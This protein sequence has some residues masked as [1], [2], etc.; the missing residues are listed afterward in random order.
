[1]STFPSSQPAGA[2][3]FP[4]RSGVPHVPLESVAPGPGS[5]SSS[6]SAGSSPAGES[7]FPILTSR[8]APRSPSAAAIAAAASPAGPQTVVAAPPAAAPPTVPIV[9]AAAPAAP[10]TT[11]LAPV[12]GATTGATSPGTTIKPATKT[13]AP[14]ELKAETIRNNAEKMKDRPLE[15][16]QLAKPSRTLKL[17]N[18]ISHVTRSY[19]DQPPDN[20]FVYWPKY[21][22]VGLVKDI[23]SAFTKA[24][25]PVTEEEIR[26]EAYDPLTPEGVQRIKEEIE[27]Y[28]GA[29]KSTKYTLDEYI[30]FAKELSGVTITETGEFVPKPI[31]GRKPE[32]NR[33]RL[34]EAINEMMEE[35]LE[36][37]ELDRVYDVSNF[38]PERYTGARK[39]AP[40]KSARAQKIR[41]EIVIGGRTYKLPFVAVPSKAHNY[42]E[43]VRRV[44]GGS[45]YRDYVD[46]AIAAFDAALRKQTGTS[47][48]PQAAV[49]PVSI[50]QVP[51]TQQRTTPV[52]P[53]PT[54]QPGG[55][56]L[57]PTTQPGGVA[58]PSATQPRGGIMLPPATQ[59]GGVPIAPPLQQVTGTQA[60]PNFPTFT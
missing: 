14:S 35:M 21:K 33:K 60:R 42:Y 7:S 2:P 47:P 27:R 22:V 31:K 40:P 45:N 18:A 20:R 44:L 56:A 53:A 46:A 50:R 55:V 24:G 48:A 37:E 52:T 34:I 3:A 17:T 23:A 19:A 6:P 36:G 28:G 12:T 32:D 59:P 25:I 5:A 8:T 26:R 10:T 38:N 58:L 54:T 41:P 11:T 13:K 1:M 39:G 30:R 15:Y 49:P 9:G 57:P 29:V 16:W 51:A 4:V 43:F